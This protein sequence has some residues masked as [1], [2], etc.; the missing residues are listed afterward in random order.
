MSV[1]ERDDI[2]I[3]LTVLVHIMYI[4]TT[5]RKSLYINFTPR[6]ILCMYVF[7]PVDSK[8]NLN[9]FK[10]KHSN[11]ILCKFQ[12]EY[13]IKLRVNY[14]DTCSTHSYNT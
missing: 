8:K 9:N 3:V 10:I 4:M 1:G 14:N 2:Q 12:V 13:S 11:N 7:L 5:E 6:H